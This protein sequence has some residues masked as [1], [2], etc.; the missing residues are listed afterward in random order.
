M[1]FANMVVI[2]YKYNCGFVKKRKMI[3]FNIIFH[4][5]E[6]LDDVSLN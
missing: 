2:S 1:T 4:S 5:G 3:V 6:T